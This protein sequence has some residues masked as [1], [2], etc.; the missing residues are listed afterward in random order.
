MRRLLLLLMVTISC[1]VGPARAARPDFDS[2]EPRLRYSRPGPAALPIA[3]GRG[4]ASP[5]VY[6]QAA[7]T[8]GV[9]TLGNV[10][11]RMDNTNFSPGNPWYDQGLSRDPSAEWPG[12]SSAEYLYFSSLWVAGKDE[13]GNHRVDEGDEIRGELADYARTRHAYAGMPGGGR[14]VDDDADGKID[15]DFLNGL[16]DDGDG[17]IDEDFAAISPD[18]FATE[19]LDYTP[20]ALDDG[21]Y[22]EPHVPM[23]LRVRRTSF[24][25]S[26]VG[27]ADFVG[28]HYEITNMTRLLD[29]VG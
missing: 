12:P 6:E 15:E 1:A 22:S 23:G 4:R 3:P 26:A 18:M 14:G 10:W 27:R 9:H 21:T 8:G 28:V 5:Q 2:A 24:A 25:W 29:G 20:Q 11:V 13:A 16:D 7:G 17:K 19:M